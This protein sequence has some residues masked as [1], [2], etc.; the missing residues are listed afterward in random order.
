MLCDRMNTPAIASHASARKITSV[1]YRAPIRVT[2]LTATFTAFALY[3]VRHLLALAHNDVWWHLRTGIWILENHA[4]PRSGLFS[5]STTLPWIDASWGFDALAALFYR[6]G[7]L[8]GLPLLLMSLQVAIAVAL[9]ALALSASA[10]FWPAIVLAVVAQFCLMPLQPQPALSSIALLAIELSLLLRARGSGNVRALF[11]L[12]PIFLLW[13]NFDWQF[14]YGLLVLALFAATVVIEQVGRQSGVAWFDHCPPGIRLDKLAAVVAASFLVT[15]FTLYGWHLHGLVLHNLSSS[16]ADRFFREMHSMRFRQPQDY[17]LLLLAQSAFFALGRR[18]SRDL[19]LISLLAVSAAVSFR[20]MRD[21][22]VVV[23]CS[24]AIIAG[25]SR[26][27][28]TDAAIAHPRHREKLSVAALVLILILI[29]ILGLP[30]NDNAHDGELRSRIEESFPVQAA[31]YI[32][33]NHLPQPLFNPRD[34]GGFLTWYLPEYPVSIDGRTDL[35]DDER[36]I[37]YFKLI[38]AE[39]PLDSDP[40]FARAQTILLEA[41]SPMAQALGTLPGF[42]EAYRDKVAIVLVRVD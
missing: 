16:P 35:Y 18:R 31:D 9:F 17:F 27:E 7:G 26:D 19:F 42:H 15:F 38:Q 11:W 21:N 41:N 12:P 6:A 20:F 25:A 24:V 40:S 39:V 30:R 4:I 14:S 2:A 3:Q 22:W 32:R 37:A 28:Q 34:W 5:Q 10:R 29:A 13:A 23:V 8:A 36:N 33:A 1:W